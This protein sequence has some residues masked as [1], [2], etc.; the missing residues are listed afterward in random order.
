MKNSVMS[1]SKN[2]CLYDMDKNK[3]C[4]VTFIPDHPL[5]DSLGINT[6]TIVTVQNKYFFGGPV[7]LQVDT[8]TIALV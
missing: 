4:Q 7:L 2:S 1:N 3:S 5:L 8:A 6:D